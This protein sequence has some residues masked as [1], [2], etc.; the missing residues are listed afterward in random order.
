MSTDATDS[1]PETALH[2]DETRPAW[3]HVRAA[4]LA[5]VVLVHGIKV[6][7]LPHKV[8]PHELKDPVAK[9]E[10]ARWSERL[11]S[12]GYTIEP[13]ELGE[14]VVDVTD[15]IS[16]VHRG[17]TA[18]FRPIMRWTGTNQG[19]ALFANPDTHPSRFRIDGIDAAGERRIL[20]QNGDPEHTW[21]LPQLKHRRIRP[22]FDAAPVRR[23][24]NAPY[25]RLG[26]WL[27]ERAQEDH[28]DLVAIELVMLETHP[29]PPGSKKKARKPKARHKTKVPK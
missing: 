26:A 28:P 29:V 6:A 5:V 19:W 13:D 23:R 17:L 14:R 12:L 8:H 7:P 11:S 1:G 4:I 9:E 22:I 25:R 21:M 10:V 3:A 18:P 20:F 2:P 16:R 24:P 27:W 15:G